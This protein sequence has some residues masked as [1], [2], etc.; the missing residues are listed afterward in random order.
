MFARYEIPYRS[1]D[2]DS[3]A[4]QENNLGGELRAALRQ[5]TGVPTIP[6]VFVGGKH[7]GGAT[8]LFDAWKSGQLQKILEENSVPYKRQVVVDPYSFLPGWL[9]PR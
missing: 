7:V 6:Q 3:V 4:Y 1:V 5:V 9:Q 2:L 8:E